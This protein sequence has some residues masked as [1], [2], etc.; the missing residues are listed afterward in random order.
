VY[1][2]GGRFVVVTIRGSVALVDQRP[3]A[4]SCDL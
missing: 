1:T 2:L 3:I 4:Q